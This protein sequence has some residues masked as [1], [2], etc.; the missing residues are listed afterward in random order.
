MSN[1]S[2]HIRKKA[3]RLPNVPALKKCS[4]SVFMVLGMNPGPFSLT[5][6]NTYIVGKG[7]RFFNISTF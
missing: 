2:N 7:T 3:Q 5:G 6:T 1:L 4:D